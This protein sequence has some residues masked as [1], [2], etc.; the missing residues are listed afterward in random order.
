MMKRYRVGG[1]HAERLADGEHHGPDVE[2]A[3]GLCRNPLPIDPNQ[4]G[5]A[6]DEDGG[7]YLRHRHALARPVHARVVGVGPEERGASVGPREGLE[8]L[9][10]PL[11][12]VRHTGC[13]RQVHRAVGHDDRIA[14]L[15]VR[16]V[17]HEHVVAEHGA[18]GRRVAQ[19]LGETRRGG[20]RDGNGRGGGGHNSLLND[21]GS[22][23]PDGQ[24]YNARS[25]PSPTS[26]LVPPTL[27]RVMASG[28][29][30]SMRMCTRLGRF[31][32][33]PCTLTMAP[34]RASGTMPW[35]TR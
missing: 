18:K 16:V 31:I 33:T 32:F 27:T 9:E 30:R 35:R 1:P 22:R 25:R 21:D 14:P 15:P 6:V 8:A 12:V 4:R 28:A 20:A 5:R 29:V 19:R 24:N 2:R 7:R 11:A 10:D 23:E 17:R 3:S 34:A 26:T 13:R